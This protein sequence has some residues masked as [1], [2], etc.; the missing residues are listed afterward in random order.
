MF[1]EGVAVTFLPFLHFFVLIS[2]LYLGFSVILNNSKSLINWS[3]FGAIAGLSLWSLQMIFLQ[4]PSTSENVAMLAI[5]IGSLGR[6]S[7]Y[8]FF[9]W[10]AL[11]FTGKRKLLK[12][13]WFVSLIVGIPLIFIG[14]QWSKYPIVALV[15]RTYGW[16]FVWQKSPFTVLYFIFSF[17]VAAIILSFIYRSGKLMLDPVKRK[18][19]AIMFFLIVFGYIPGY[20]V[21]IIFPLLKFYEFP[22]IANVFPIFW[23]IG[24]VYSINKYKF[25]AVTSSTAAENIITAMDDSL[26]LLDPEGKILEANNATCKLLGYEDKELI[27][28]D[29]DV[30]I[31]K[32]G[33]VDS[34]VTSLDL[35][36]GL[37]TIGDLKHKERAY[38]T[39]DNKMIPMLFSVS[40]IRDILG[41]VQGIVVIAKDIAEIKETEDQLR[42]LNEELIEK[43]KKRLT[44]MEE[45]KITNI[46]LKNSQEQLI[47]SEKLAS[48]GR[49]VADMAHEVNNP[50]MI[51]TGRAQLA[52]MQKSGNDNI[53]NSLRIIVDQCERA[54][55]IIHRLLLFSQPSRGESKATNLNE[56][57][58]LV[59]QLLEHQYMLANISFVKNYGKDLPIINVDEKQIHEV[60]MNLLKN[61][62]EAMPDGGT[63]EVKT[64][65]EKENYI[66]NIIDSGIGIKKENIG[67]IFDPFFST[68]ESG[69]GL[70][71]SVCYGIIKAHGGELSYSSEP[72]QGTIVSISLPINEK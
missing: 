37:E 72:G 33:Q 55:C 34:I 36:L 48:L 23:A 49:L 16:G 22:P 52:Q 42:H 35:I 1:L 63:I 44:A 17:F 64:F 18:N 3:C 41:V 25:L 45:L 6:Y 68:K 28:K 9:I 12:K 61:S 43:E 60:L 51:I 71:L 70:G 13:K 32:M 5:K 67:K 21:N 62:G 30:L 10:F 20:I 40:S 14:L 24:L 8:S 2:Y 65:V 59:V 11:E 53:E 69:T 57:V 27:G 38:L 58:D 31:P 26:I 4:S 46:E 7:F 47:Q 39:K 56:V 29:V 50:L 15:K 66:V 54:K 19:T